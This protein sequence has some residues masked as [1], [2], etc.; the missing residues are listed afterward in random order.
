M[1][2]SADSRAQRSELPLGAD[3]ARLE[4]R[5]RQ[6]QREQDAA[7]RRLDAFLP[8][9]PDGLRAAWREYCEVM[10]ELEEATAALAHLRLAV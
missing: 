6:L 10:A 9:K 8:G 2:A 3:V 1:S 4:S 7:R 5:Q